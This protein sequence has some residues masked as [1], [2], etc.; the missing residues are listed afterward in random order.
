LVE[1]LLGEGVPHLDVLHA[2]FIEGSLPEFTQVE[3]GLARTGAE[4]AGP[5][6]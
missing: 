4:G 3:G 1:L 5:I 2:A 6:G